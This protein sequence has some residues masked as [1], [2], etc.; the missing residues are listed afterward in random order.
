MPGDI[1]GEFENARDFSRFLQAC[2]NLATNYESDNWSNPEK[3]STIPEQM[4]RIIQSCQQVYRMTYDPTNTE[5]K[6]ICIRINRTLQDYALD[7]LKLEW[8]W[9]RRGKALVYD[10]GV[11]PVGNGRNEL[12][13]TRYLSGAAIIKHDY[14]AV[15]QPITLDTVQFEQNG[16]P[17]LMGT[18]T[19]GELDSICSVPWMD[20]KIKSS[21]FGKLLLDGS[22]DS[23]KWQRVVDHER[24]KSIRKFAEGEKNNLLNPV[25]LFVNAESVSISEGD[26]GHRIV[27]IPFDFLVERHGV[28]TDYFPLPEDHDSR[29]IW[30]IDGQHRIRGFG[31]SK[32]GS[33]MS[34]PFVLIVGDN[35]TTTISKVAKLF[36]EINTKSEELSELHKI[37]LN[38]RYG[39]V[40]T[41]GDFSFE[42]E[43]GMPKID[44]E[45][46]PIP[47][48][49]GRKCR[50]AYEL[51]LFMTSSEDSPIYDSIQFQKPPGVNSNPKWVSDAHKW[52]QTVQGWFSSGIYGE[53]ESD[54]FC[55]NECMSFF[56]AFKELCDDWPSGGSRWHV[57]ATADKQL[58][59]R[60]GTFPV[61][62]NIFQY[63]VE[64]IASSELPRPPISTEEFVEFMQP[65]KWVDWRHDR[66]NSAPLSG[67]N[68]TNW[69]HLEMWVKT[70]IENGVSYSNSEILDE[71]KE[72]IPGMG[73]IA[74]PKRQEITR[75]GP[76]KFPDMAPLILKVKKPHHCT[77]LQWLVE[78]GSGDAYEKVEPKCLVTEYEGEYN[79]LTIK[80]PCIGTHNSI[81]VKVE[82]TNG[83][84]TRYS[85]E[86]KYSKPNSGE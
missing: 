24:V 85:V 3:S 10:D 66:I 41:T 75:V 67:Q 63:C 2:M 16:L 15:P 79:I 39:M 11:T 72:S 17:A 8:G 28:Y 77:K 56:K 40:S 37:Y 76:T 4:A 9:W 26:G 31:S 29:P 82:F 73:L 43:N 32:K 84:G 42:V 20:P 1:E 19:A 54:L 25:L 33:K 58:F 12:L 35:S 14:Y 23:N 61:L 71:T 27:E 62:L 64:E 78:A 57:G 47:T 53:K 7:P 45:G 30:I 51:A 34:I 65:I 49:S 48:E 18:A 55:R 68:N 36:T 69:K 6:R 52:M 46:L 81:K 59:Q 21:E 83:M 80:Q 50:R 86:K 70:A 38:Y 60:R 13:E 5:L 22:L 74:Q 44:S